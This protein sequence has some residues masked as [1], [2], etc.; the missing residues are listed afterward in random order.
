MS[1]Y[2]L[3]NG[4]KQTAKILGQYEIKYEN[5]GNKKLEELTD[6]LTYSDNTY[7]MYFNNPLLFALFNTHQNQISKKKNI[8]N[9]I[10]D[11]SSENIVIKV[12]QF[13]Y[14]AKTDDVS[15]GFVDINPP[16]NGTNVIFLDSSWFDQIKDD[17]VKKYALVLLEQYYNDK[18]NTGDKDK[19]KTLCAQIVQGGGNPIKGSTRSRTLTKTR[20]RKIPKK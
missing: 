13:G 3:I 5:G 10:K 9:S 1:E 16:S 8:S 14:E 2:T 12:G 6:L 19:I 17:E 20:K 11:T 7:K 18:D 15:F 4:V